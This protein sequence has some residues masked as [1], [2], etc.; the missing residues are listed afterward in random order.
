MRNLLSIILLFFAVT[1]HAQVVGIEVQRMV[2]DTIHAKAVVET[3]GGKLAEERFYRTLKSQE[4]IP[5][6]IFI[7][8]GERPFYQLDSILFY[9]YAVDGSLKNIDTIYNSVSQYQYTQDDLSLKINSYFLEGR[10]HSKHTLEIGV[11]NGT[12]QDYT[13][14]FNS[15]EDPITYQKENT[16]LLNRATKYLPIEVTFVRGRNEYYVEVKNSN[17]YSKFISIETV[18][19]DLLDDDFTPYANKSRTKKM[20]LGKSPDLYL[21]VKGNY[22]LLTI[23]NKN[24]ERKFPVSQLI[25]P[26]SKEYF[27]K[28]KNVLQLQNLSTGAI[29]VAAIKIRKL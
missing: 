21:E 17:G 5:R 20:K 28:G 25:N 9:S 1:L 3:L 8:N 10:V 13:I 2:N 16:L 11:H 23:V 4:N 22:K 24:G 18:G 12:P 26:I 15:D 27:T 14:T 19:Y 7:D 6:Q 29:K